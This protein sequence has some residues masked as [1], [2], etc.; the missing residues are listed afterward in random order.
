ME[1]GQNEET[2]LVAERLRARTFL[3][4]L[5]QSGLDPEQLQLNE[6]GITPS[7]DVTIPVVDA[8][9]LDQAVKEAQASLLP[10]EAALEYMVTDDGI[11]LWIV[12]SERTFGPE[13]ILYNRKHLLRD[14]VALRRAIEPQ[15]K[16]VNGEPK[17]IFS[18]PSELLGRFYE[19]LIQPALSQLSK[20]VDTLIVIPSG[21]LWYVPFSALVMTDQ[22]DIEFGSTGVGGTKQYRQRY[23]IDKYTLAFLPSLAS[24]PILMEERAPSTAMY[25]ALANPT[26]SEKQQEEVGSHYQFSV[27]ETACQSF[28]E[29]LGKGREEV[30]VQGDALEERAYNEAAGHEVL[31]YACHGIFNP[32]V[33]LDSRL[34]LAPSKENEQETT[35]RRLAD[36]D[37]YAFEVILT[38][39]KGVDLVILAAC[40][41]L[42]PTL[43]EVQGALGMTLGARS[44]EKLNA[45]QLELIVAGDEVVGLSRAFLSSGARSV[46][47]TLWQA[48][49]T[50]IDEL[51]VALCEAHKEVGSWAAALRQ[52][53]LAILNESD[54]LFTLTYQTRLAGAHPW[55]W[56]PYQLIGRWR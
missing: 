30:Y 10:N 33:P 45:Q 16:E 22:P 20:G 7:E 27:L 18:N 51:L 21:P 49:P 54:P 25:L 34:L 2:I 6:A 12:I 1:L 29:C 40:E 44:D 53:Q 3:D 36:G 37:Y 48:N 35:D 28:S 32:S 23:L 42:L 43:R 24:L 56:A 13:F 46:L 4:S 14:V 39:H 55:F 5:Y 38:D 11:Y 26:L 19:L 9:A 31:V 47:G 52:A 15:T 8:A 50:A 17:I 41:T